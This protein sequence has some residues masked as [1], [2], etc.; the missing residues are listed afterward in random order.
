MS[1]EAELLKLKGSELAEM[2]RAKKLPVSGTKAVLVA[3]LL[4]TAPPA[5]RASKSNGPA[6]APTYRAPVFS[7]LRGHA[8]V[9]VLKKNDSG[10]FVD[11]ESGFVFDPNSKLVVGRFASGAVRALCTDDLVE[12]ETRRFGADLSRIV[13]KAAAAEDLEA[14]YEKV[15]ADIRGEGEEEQDD[16]EE[17]DTD[18]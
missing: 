1:T 17:E 6:T 11:S 14:R 2:C 5:K 15:V 18:L 12:C 7:L 9:I 13:P 10:A 4:G 8:D 16:A 3:R